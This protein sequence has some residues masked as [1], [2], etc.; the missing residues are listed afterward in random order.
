MPPAI[1]SFQLTLDTT[2]SLH[3][4]A[5]TATFAQEWQH[6]LQTTE[7][8]GVQAE[9]HVI[10]AASMVLSAVEQLDDHTAQVLTALYRLNGQLPAPTDK[11]L[12]GLLE[13]RVDE[14]QFEV[15][16]QGD[17]EQVVITYRLDIVR[18]RYGSQQAE[19]SKSLPVSHALQSSTHM[20]TSQYLGTGE[21][22]IAPNLS[23][24]L[25]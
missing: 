20:S 12:V 16:S 9:E 18:Y 7:V 19:V 15:S 21:I 11:L 2:I 1:F 10:E 23:V 8:S 5:R 25:L 14:R 24:Y 22:E 3:W 6:R 4:S 17:N 13:L